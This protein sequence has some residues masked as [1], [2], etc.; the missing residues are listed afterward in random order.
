VR[1][2]EEEEEEGAFWARGEKVRWGES[3]EVDGRR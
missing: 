2:R 3:R 1:N